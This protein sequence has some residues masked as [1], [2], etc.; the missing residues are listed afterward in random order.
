[1]QKLFG[2]RSVWIS[3]ARNFGLGAVNRLSPLK[4]LLIRHAVA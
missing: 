1:L 2:A 3:G 4:N